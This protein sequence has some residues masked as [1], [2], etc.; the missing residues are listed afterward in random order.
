MVG[1]EFSWNLRFPKEKKK[2]K[3]KSYLEELLRQ[4]MNTKPPQLLPFGTC[5]LVIT[6]FFLILSLSGTHLRIN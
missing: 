2:K 3:K 4:V 6:F 1:N 5:L